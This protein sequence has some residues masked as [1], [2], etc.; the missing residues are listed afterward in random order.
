MTCKYAKKRTAL[1]REESD[2]IGPA[3]IQGEDFKRTPD[4]TW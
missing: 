2:F 4:G 1:G 3:G